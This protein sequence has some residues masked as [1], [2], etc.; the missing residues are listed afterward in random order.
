MT[1]G[2]LKLA[3][4]FAPLVAI[5]VYLDPLRALVFGG[6]V[7]ALLLSAAIVDRLIR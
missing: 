2:R 4:W 5:F 3:I 6:I 1:R 7:G